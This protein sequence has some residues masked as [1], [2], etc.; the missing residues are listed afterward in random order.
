MTKSARSK[1]KRTGP[2][3]WLGQV[4]A[5]LVILSI[6]TVIVLSVIAPRIGG[7]TPYTILNGSMT[8]SM[9]PGTLAVTRV[10]PIDEIGVGSVIT[11]QLESG[12]PTVVTHRVVSTGFSGRGEQTFRTQGDANSAVDEKPVLPVQIKGRLWYKVPYLGYVNTLIT[13][14]GRDFTMVVVVTFLLLYAA[15]MF[16]SAAHDRVRKSRERQTQGATS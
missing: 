6:G 3:G 10:V 14:K 9:P 15:Y 8:P 16:A 13:G 4:L 5:W 12:K 1:D 11:Y 2:L 7:G